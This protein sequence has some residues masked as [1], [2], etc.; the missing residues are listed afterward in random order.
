ML[1]LCDLQP[2]IP[3]WD[4]QLHTTLRLTGAVVVTAAIAGLG[5]GI[6]ASSVRRSRLS[7]LLVAGLGAYPLCI[8]V[9]VTAL[10]GGE[11]GGVR[12]NLRILPLLLFGAVPYALVA[13]V[14]LV[15]GI[16]LL[17]RWTRARA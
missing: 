15:L 3:S 10:I 4:E 11:A 2:G 5:L 1:S 12:G 17:E 14:P 6:F 8:M 9:D 13:G 16:Y 7:W